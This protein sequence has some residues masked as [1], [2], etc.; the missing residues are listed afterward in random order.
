LPAGCSSVNSGIVCKVT[1]GTTRTFYTN[2]S[3]TTP[4]YRQ[5]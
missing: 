4:Y 3:C 2:P 5:P 1:S